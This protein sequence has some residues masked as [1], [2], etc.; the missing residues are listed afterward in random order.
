MGEGKRKKSKAENEK[1]ICTRIQGFKD[2]KL[3]PNEKYTYD[4]P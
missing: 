2:S 1:E 3:T 4:T